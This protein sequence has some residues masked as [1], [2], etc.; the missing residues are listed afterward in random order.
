MSEHAKPALRRIQSHGAELV[1][2]SWGEAGRPRIILLHGGGQTRHAWRRS[3]AHLAELG[4][5][6][7][8]PDLRGHGESAWSPDGRYTG[9]LFA[10]DVRAWCAL[11][12]APPVVVGASL[13]GLSS[14]LALGEPPRAAVRALVL[15]DIAHRGEPVGVSRILDFMR[16]HPDGFES[17]EH[18]IAVVAKYLPHRAAASAGEGLRKN[19]RERDG[20][21]KWHWDPRLLEG[22]NPG[23]QREQNAQRLLRAARAI[24]APILLVRGAESDLL[25]PE[26]A[27][28]FCREVPRARRVDVH[29]ARHMV[30]GDQNDP[31]LD[32]IVE[33]L[34]QPELA[35]PVSAQ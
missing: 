21:L 15:V 3:G 11:E 17:F 33:F 32:V 10:D 22:T 12:P 27:D 25:S 6:V 7:L 24:E 35:Q 16:A 30:A 8:V 13:G 14:L 1:A 31:F 4:Y 2:E 19:L 28:Q 20:R 18:A 34:A 5:H 9:E 29:G 23:E 26:I